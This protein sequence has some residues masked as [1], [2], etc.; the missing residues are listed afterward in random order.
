MFKR[1]VDIIV[2]V[3]G[4][5]IF[6]P[7]IV[8]IAVILMINNNGS[9]FFSHQRP[10]KDCRPFNLF[11]FKTMTDSKDENGQLLPNHQR[12]T[13]FGNILRRYSL[14]ELP[15]LW[16]VLIGD[17]SL[18]GPRP[19]EMR[20]LELYNNEQIRRHSVKPGI[21]G[22]AQ[23]EGRNSIS[24]EE[25]FKLDIWYVDNS[26]FLLDLRI[27]LKTVVVVMSGKGVNETDQSTVLP[28][29]EYLKNK[30]SDEI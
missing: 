19:L 11:K 9:I 24:W 21:T 20:Y 10:G 4:L 2:A 5:F 23:V 16:N 26:T 1:V 7:V 29:D 28:F 13:R 12:I 15:Q 18:V 6:S 17:I 22:M 3:L 25:K 27:I 30:K 8:L 14:D